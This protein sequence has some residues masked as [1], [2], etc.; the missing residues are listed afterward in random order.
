MITGIILASGFSRRM[1]G[2]KLLLPVQGIALAERVMQAAD[3]SR[4]D[5]TILVYQNPAVRKLAERYRIRPVFNTHAAEGQSASVKAGVLASLPATKA[6]VFLTAD[7][8]WLEAPII[9][10]LIAV[11]QKNKN[12]IIVPAYDGTRGSPVIFP[13]QLRD[14]LLALT[15][16]RGGR[17]VME[18]LPEMVRCIDMPDA[19]AGIDIDTPEDY[20][21]LTP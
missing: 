13:V 14:T 6:Y 2:D 9:D 15:G 16:D 4:L 18:Q 11:W 7:Q 1:G 12:R 10:L 8:P 17:A 21:A 3:A 19:A 20:D 5:D